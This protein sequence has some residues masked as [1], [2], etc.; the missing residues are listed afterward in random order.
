MDDRA[1]CYPRGTRAD[2]GQGCRRS[3]CQ[4]YEFRHD[5]STAASNDCADSEASYGTSDVDAESD[6]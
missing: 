6:A 3:R 5:S 4:T 2:G 1:T